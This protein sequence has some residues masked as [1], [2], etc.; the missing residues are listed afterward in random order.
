MFENSYKQGI[1][2]GCRVA[3]RCGLG[4]AVCVC[5]HVCIQNSYIIVIL[6]GIWNLSEYNKN[7]KGEE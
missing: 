1:T 7:I 5:V 4:T 6:Y 2:G 3:A